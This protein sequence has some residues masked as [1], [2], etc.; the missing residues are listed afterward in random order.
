MSLRESFLG[1]KHLISKE[2]E[3]GRGSVGGGLG[4]ERMKRQSSLNGTFRQSPKHAFF[5]M[6]VG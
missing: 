2:R 5:Y 6:Q 1:E 3:K 4:R